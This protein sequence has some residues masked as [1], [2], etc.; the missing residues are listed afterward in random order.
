MRNGDV[1]DSG[2]RNGKPW[3]P[4]DPGD[5]AK[6]TASPGSSLFGSLAR[7]AASAVSLNEEPPQ[8]RTRKSRS[9]PKGRAAKLNLGAWWVT[10]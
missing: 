6:I 2:G 1:G 10:T 5:V 3:R 8:P 4:G 9:P 7:Y